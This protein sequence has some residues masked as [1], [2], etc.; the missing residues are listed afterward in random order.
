MSDD[1]DN[2]TLGA[3]T[4]PPPRPVY[5]SEKP[6]GKGAF[7]E[8]FLAR[9]PSGDRVAV[10]TTTSTVPTQEVHIL[11]L[12]A[13]YKDV[14]SNLLYLIDVTQ[15]PTGGTTIV[16]NYVEGMEVH[17]GPV[18]VSYMHNLFL[19]VMSTLEFLHTNRIVHRDIKRENV[20]FSPPNK[21]VVIDYGSACERRCIGGGGT[22]LYF[23]ED[24]RRA[25]YAKTTTSWNAY[26][27]A[28]LFALGV[29]MYRVIYK[30]LPYATPP[31]NDEYRVYL[32]DKPKPFTYEDGALNEAMHTLLAL[33][34]PGT[35][36]TPRASEV[37]AT[38]N[39]RIFSS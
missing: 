29:L 16:T 15:E 23:T 37:L 9:L 12:L 13:N 8:V 25:T 2:T 38:Y 19:Q 39:Q 32:W 4:P 31:R 20:L 28:D 10:K 34:P 3:G 26:R 7:G 6:L 35:S 17:K 33:G 18:S 22:P 21:F 1:D 30:S 27:A 5:V 11:T 24:V 36:P 14:Y